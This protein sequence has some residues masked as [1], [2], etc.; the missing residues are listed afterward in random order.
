MMKYFLWSSQVIYK[1]NFFTLKKTGSFKK[2]LI[3]VFFPFT[4]FLLI[5]NLN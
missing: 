5:K 1:G 4:W 3:A 2:Y